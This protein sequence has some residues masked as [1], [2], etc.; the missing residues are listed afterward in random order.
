[1]TMPCFLVVI[2]PVGM[3]MTVVV[4]VHMLM[5][6]IVPVRVVMHVIV[7]VL[8]PMLMPVIVQIFIHIVSY[9]GYPGACNAMTLVRR[10]LQ[11]PSLNVEFLQAAFKDLPTDPKVKHRPQ[12]H[13]TADSG[14]AVVIQYL[15]PDFSFFNTSCAGRTV[16]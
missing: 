9:Y 15:H 7:R 2:V 14:K 10:Y 3:L 16:A 8:V 1:M 6:V 12:V 11:P 5:P 13:V 4:R